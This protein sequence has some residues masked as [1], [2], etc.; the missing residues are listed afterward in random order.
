MCNVGNARSFFP[1]KGCQEMEA[2]VVSIVTTLDKAFSLTKVVVGE[3]GIG[4]R[5]GAVSL[6]SSF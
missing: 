4:E 3:K 1:N 6:L 5:Q 2:T